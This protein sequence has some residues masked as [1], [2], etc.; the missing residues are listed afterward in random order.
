MIWS[1]ECVK[2]GEKKVLYYQMNNKQKKSGHV[3]AAQKTALLDFLEINPKLRT[4][5]YEP[6]FTYKDGER[7]WEEAAVMLNAIPGSQKT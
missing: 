5:K 1:E 7:L 3:S 4:G 6:S 2:V